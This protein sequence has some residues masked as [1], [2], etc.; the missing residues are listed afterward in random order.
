M[1]FY[2]VSI[3]CNRS[4]ILLLL[5]CATEPPISEARRRAEKEYDSNGHG[6]DGRIGYVGN[7]G[8]TSGE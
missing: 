2:E 3:F 7:A 6:I 1:V 5:G 8:A 4:H